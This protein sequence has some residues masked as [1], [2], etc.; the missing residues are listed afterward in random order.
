MT[1]A[2]ALA[3]ALRLA[4][5]A[6]AGGQEVDEVKTGSVDLVDGGHLNIIN[7]TC[8][9]DGGAC[10][11]YLPPDSLLATGQELSRLQAENASLKA[12]P[13]PS[14]SVTLVIVAALV[15]AALGAGAVIATKH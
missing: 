8:G 4:T 10:G 9:L 7:P 11:G 5:G 6:A 12:D 1:R 13:G 2:L 3:L 14:T 15:G